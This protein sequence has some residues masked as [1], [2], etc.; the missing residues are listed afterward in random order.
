MPLPE[1][2]PLTASDDEIVA[3]LAEAEL[4]ALLPAL[5]HL[6]GDRT[7]LDPEL[8]VDPLLINEAQGGLTPEQQERV[9]AVAAEVLARWRDDGRPPPATP[10]HDLLLELM[11]FAVGGG[12]MEDYLPLLEEELGVTPD[13]RRAPTWHKDDLAPDRRAHGGRHRGRHVRA[14]RRPPAGPGRRALRRAREERGGRRDLVGEHLSGVPGRQPEPPLQLLL[15]P[16]A[17]LA[18]A[19]LHP[20]RAAG[21]LPRLRRRA[22]PAPLHPLRHRG[23][24]GRVRR[25]RRPLDAGGAQPGRDDRAPRG[26]RRDQRRGPAQPAAHAGHRRSGHVRG[27]VASTRPGGITRS[28]CA[29]GGWG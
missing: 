23:P 17:R 21:L 15:R 11:E 10:S 7:L 13:D 20:G 9:R 4:P 26:R 18:P 19:L 27:A 28:I 14:A 5:A 25:H 22:R 29:A 12:A 2:E 3:A 1:T 6:T 16:E 24:V 8:R